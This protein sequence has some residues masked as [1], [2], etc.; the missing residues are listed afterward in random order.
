MDNVRDI[1]KNR[2]NTIHTNYERDNLKYDDW[3]DLF[4]DKIKNCTTPIIDLGCGS[5]NDTLYLLEKG[6]EVIPC[7]YSENAIENIKKNFPEIQRT[8]CFDM[9]NGLPF[10][11]DFTDIIIADLTLH[12]FL[13]KDTIKILEEIKRVLKSKG[14]LI[15]RVNSIND[16]LYGAGKGLEVEK[17]LYQTDDMGYKRFFDEK[18]IK[19]FLNGWD[20]SYMQEEDMTRYDKPKKLWRCL[21]KANK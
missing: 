13:E 10:P 15:F 20:I 8:E 9:V 21:A 4:E 5:G 12:Y 3:L 2:W 1:Q 19:Y 16:V 17:H 7:D 6:K 11:N 18:D 14:I